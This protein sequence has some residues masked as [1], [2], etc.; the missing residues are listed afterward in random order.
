MYLATLRSVFASVALICTTVTAW[1]E[2]S[3]VQNF[4]TAV[5][6]GNVAG[7]VASFT[8]GTR[9]IDLGNDFSK[10]DRLQWFCNEVVVQKA[11][12]KLLTEEV[13]DNT[14]SF[15]FD[16]TAGNYFLEGKGLATVEQGKFK[17]LVIERR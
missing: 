11:N 17:E 3:A 6:S 5:N 13:K 14:I 15:T 12:Y 4:A 10:P 16:F 1:A 9:F 8:K 2:T 7:C